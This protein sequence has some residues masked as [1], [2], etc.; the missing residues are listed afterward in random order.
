[1]TLTL[2]PVIEAEV[3]TTLEEDVQTAE[4]A[5]KAPGGYRIE[6]ALSSWMSARARLLSEDAELAH[7]E[8]AMT[9]LLGAED[10]N[11]Q[12]I[13][14]RL[15][16]AAVHATSMASAAADQIEAIKGRQDRYKRRVEAM[17]ATAYAILDAIGQVK[18]ELPDL[19]ASIRKGTQSAMIVD[20][21]AIP[22]KYVEIVTTR[23]IDK[24]VI[25]S[26]LRSGEEVP[27]AFLSNG[28]ATLAIRTK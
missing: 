21:A 20:E 1:M 24:A 16:R 11:V 15:L 4:R 7:D 2:K 5:I 26:T 9:E 10:G 13:L 12:D 28:M 3:T 18:V 6:Q 14:A 23:K 19:T 27:G 25:L 22:D 17:R 8:A